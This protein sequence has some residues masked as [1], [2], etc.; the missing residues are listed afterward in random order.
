MISSW[1]EPP[2]TNEVTPPPIPRSYVCF[3]VSFT[4]D[5]SGMPV[6]KREPFDKHK[7]VELK[8]ESLLCFKEIINKLIKGKNTNKDIRKLRDIHL[9]INKIIG[10][11]RYIEAIDELCKMISKE[12]NKKMEYY[13]DI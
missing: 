10:N 11:G 4:L 2:I 12:N 5:D 8:K 7:L 3:G 13:N 1:P 9:E 6:P